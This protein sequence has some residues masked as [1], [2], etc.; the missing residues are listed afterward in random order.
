MTSDLLARGK[1]ALKAGRK[2]EARALFERVIENDERSEQAWLWLSGAVDTDVDRRICLENVLEI[3]PHNGRARKALDLLRQ[4]ER[5]GSVSPAVSVRSLKS[6]R[7]LAREIAPPA[8]MATEAEATPESP[9]AAQD[10]ERAALTEA[11]EEDERDPSPEPSGGRGMRW[12]IGC[13]A[14]LALLAIAAL[15]VWWVMSG[16]PAGAPI[17][18]TASLTFTPTRPRSNGAP[19]TWTPAPSVTPAGT[20]TPRPSRTARPTPTPVLTWTPTFTPTATLT[21]TS[22]LTP[23]LTAPPVSTLTLP[24]TWTPQ[25]TNTPPPGMTL[26]PTW[27]PLPTSTL[28]PAPTPSPTSTLTATVTATV[29]LTPTAET[30]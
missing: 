16:A 19:P 26:P 10:D 1:A 7:D 3:N 29:T 30:E 5:Q 25:A 15:G 14:L 11:P 6:Q 22:T 18:S 12:A 8:S 17:A 24:P 13:G 9:V 21:G 27:T 28:F 23:T 2:A 20:A 4:R